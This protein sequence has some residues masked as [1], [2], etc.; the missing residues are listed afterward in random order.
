MTS[1]NNKVP[2]LIT[3]AGPVGLTMA[4]EL[5]RHGIACR[6]IDKNTAR[7]DKS[8]ALGVHARTLEVFENI[9]I[10]D[11]AL[12]AG[13]EV[14]G[15]HA[16][17]NKK[18]AFGFV[19][20]DLDSPYPFV[21]MLA[22]SETER[23]L[24]EHLSS[25]GIKVERQVELV[26]FTQSDQGVTAQLK[27][28]DGTS[29]TCQTNWLIGCDGAHSTVRHKLNLTFD[30]APYEEAFGLAD[31]D[32]EW[33]NSGT[34]LSMYL[35]EHGILVFFP[36][37]DVRYRIIVSMPADAV[38]DSEPVL[39]DFQQL[40]NVRGPGNT[41]LSNPRWLAWFRIHRRAVKTYRTGRIFLAGDAAH[42]H[43]PAGGQGMNTGIQDAYN[44]SWKLALVESQA[45]SAALLDTYQEERHPVAQEVLKGTDMLTKAMTTHN[46]IIQNVRNAVMPMILGQ[47]VMQKR[48]AK[49][50]SEIG[51]NYRH[52]SIVGQHEAQLK[53]V[54]VLP[55]PACANPNIGDWLEFA[56]GPAAGDRAPDVKV[57]D[58][59]NRLT[60]R[61]FQAMRGTQFT[62][63][64]FA[65]T[66]DVEHVIPEFLD[67]A[68]RVAEQYSPHINTFL[69]AQKDLQIDNDDVR[70]F[71]DADLSWHQRYAA[72]AE[73]LYLI[74]P[75]GYIG[76]RS[77]PADLASL[78]KHLDGIFSQ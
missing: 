22:Q 43:S 67:I 65:G 33:P 8:K 12:A 62:L 51:V 74:R 44:L 60:S 64:L 45:A 25:Y 39:D 76:F 6:I 32:V 37:N 48:L 61:L 29:E 50:M 52:S 63:F 20:K 30:G 35:D 3:G 18:P 31:V 15:A 58:A 54:Q 47:E 27:H 26:D 5:A 14:H 56:H 9:G 46:P 36:F 11:K 19:F 77:Q 71:I 28:C 72:G 24:E 49:S 53:Q 38:L 78:T 21:L 70:M 23:I 7:T 66:R 41:K 17:L 2:V 40:I 4:C 13:H 69:I 75:D 42:I 10:V 59:T 16:Y 57:V 68:K 1:S 34:E 73:C 55:A